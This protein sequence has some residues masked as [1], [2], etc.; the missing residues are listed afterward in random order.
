MNNTIIEACVDSIGSAVNAQE[1]GAARV[2]LC[3]NILEGG[4]TPG[5]GTI[6]MAR[7][8]LD[9]ELFVM[10]RPRGGDFLYSDPE[11]ETM[12]KDVGLA[13][14][15]GADGVV[16]GV[17]KGDGSI[18]MERNRALKELASPLKTTFHRA[19]DLCAD[20]WQSLEDIISIG[21]D[22]IL[23]SGQAPSAMEGL[24]LIQKLVKKAAGR[25]VIM[26]GGGINEENINTLK[27]KTGTTEFHVSLREEWR[28][29]MSFRKDGIF[30]GKGTQSE[31]SRMVTSIERIRNL[32]KIL[33]K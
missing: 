9:I 32:K 27:Q 31:Y 14:E 22:R 7:E 12:L 5:F 10:I 25:V 3:D 21:M 28:S 18:D 13:R 8:K 17:L 26:P 11:F 20:P 1:G 29:G 16:F 23:T 2:E 19:F 24:N 6:A 15:L 33:Q 30:M 4:T